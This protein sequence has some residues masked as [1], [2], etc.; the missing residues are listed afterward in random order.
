M[1]YAKGGYPVEAASKIGHLKIVGSP[2]IRNL[3]ENFETIAPTGPSLIA[4]SVDT[5]DLTLPSDLLYVVTVDGGE[6]IV[7]N[8]L[9]REKT[10]AFIQAAA[11]LLKVSDLEQMRADPM[12]DPRDVGKLLNDKTWVNVAV[13]PLSGVKVPG[14]T[15]R[16]TIRETVHHTLA[17]AGLY[18]TLSFLVSRDW[19][20]SY[21]MPGAS[22]PRFN[23][24]SCDGEIVLPRATISFNCPHCAGPHKLSDYL[25][26]GQES[27]DDWS[28]Q[29]AASALRDTMETLTLFHFVRIY[30]GQPELLSRILFIKDGPL[31]LRAA[32][33]R[34]V[35][36]IRALVKHVKDAGTSL[37]MIGIEKNGDLANHLDE[38]Q[39]QLPNPGDTFIPTVQYLVEEVSGQVFPLNY[40]NR[41]SYGAKVLAR[42]GPQHLL[43]LNI[44]TGDF[45]VNPAQADLI[46]F[47]N[48]V[49]CLC[50]L[51]SYRYPNAL[52]PLVLAN[53]AASI[54]L[55]PSGP[56]LKQF[57]DNLLK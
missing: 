48:T 45:L 22:S 12:M 53:S 50:E 9:R 36:P 24:W 18:D 55:K 7:P 8:Q 15:V 37:H 28:R 43:V 20:P 56:I 1:A 6:A 26:I 2:A 23:C 57:L 31:L 10:V 46:G 35:E 38:F 33:S 49:R 11:C 40:R 25:G 4:R 17:T 44:P 13:L 14:Q 51:I 39:S 27:P 30:L 34:L 54:S 21:L 29:E 16:A 42:L 32:L 52:L 5:V 41:V 3:I 19:D 47:S